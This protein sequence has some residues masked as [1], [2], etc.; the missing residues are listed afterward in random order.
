MNSHTG[1]PMLKTNYYTTNVFE[2]SSGALLPRLV[3]G[4][5]LP[6]SWVYEG[7]QDVRR[8][9]YGDLIV[10]TDDSLTQIGSA[11]STVLARFPQR[12]QAGVVNTA[13]QAVANTSGAVAI[14]SGTN[15]GV[16]Q[17]SVVQNGVANMIAYLGN[18]TQYRTASPGGGFFTQSFDL[19]V[20]DSGNV[21]ANLAVNGGPNGIYEYS[22]GKWSAVMK[23]GDT[24]DGRTVTG[25]NSIRVAGS[26]CF[27]VIATQGNFPHLARYQNGTWTDLINYGDALA[28]G[29]FVSNIGNFDAN[30]K[31][32]V[33]AMVNGSG[34]AQYLLFT[35]G[36]T[37]A[38]AAAT[39]Q[40]M[41]SGEYLVQVFQV[42][43]NDDGRIFLTAINQYDQ[44]VLYEF[45]PLF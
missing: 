33:S 26:Y 5:L 12:Q 8:N 16:Q 22:Q 3:D 7:N 34:G 37:A 1:N 13:F 29:G 25:I 45:D 18:N 27:A 38:V 6:G 31:G 24:Y 32:A 11:A 36:V 43:L 40:A 44:M 19:G 41:P 2:L 23:V 9:G 28:I 14:T 30:R 4:D 35:D 39:D 42:C 20:D 15:F 17:M 10:A 21:Y